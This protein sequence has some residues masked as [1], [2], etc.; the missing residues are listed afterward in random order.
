MENGLGNT[1]GEKTPNFH[2]D[3]SIKNL[4]LYKVC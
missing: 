2:C 4:R 3:P 1:K